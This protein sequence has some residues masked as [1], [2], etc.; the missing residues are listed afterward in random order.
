VP[1]GRLEAPHAPFPWSVD[2]NSP[3]DDS[4]CLAVGAPLKV[5]MVKYLLWV[6]N[7]RN[8]CIGCAVYRV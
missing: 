1:G 6:A 8:A 4:T 2:G 5:S 7:S 3:P